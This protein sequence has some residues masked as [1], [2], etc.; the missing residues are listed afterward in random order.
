MRHWWN[1]LLS[2]EIST[3][4]NSSRSFLIE[5]SIQ[6]RLGILSSMGSLVIEGKE[7]SQYPPAQIF[8]LRD[9][10]SEEL[11]NWKKD[12]QPLTANDFF[13]L[14]THLLKRIHLIKPEIFIFEG[15]IQVKDTHYFGVNLIST[16]PVGALFFNIMF[17]PQESINLEDHYVI[18]HDPDLTLDL[19][20]VHL[21]STSLM[22]INLSTKEIL[23]IGHLSMGEIKE[24]I[25]S[26]MSIIL[27]QH[28]GLPMGARGIKDLEGSRCLV[29][30][31]DKS[32]DRKNLTND[33]LTFSGYDQFCLQDG[34]VQNLF[35]G[36]CLKES[37]LIEKSNE[38][39]LLK[40]HQFGN[41]FEGI[42]LDKITREPLLEAQPDKK[43]GHFIFSLP[44]FWHG[45]HHAFNPS[46]LFLFYEDFSGVFPLLG[47]L[48]KEE[49]LSYLL[50]ILHQTPHALSPLNIYE[51]L[52]SQFLDSHSL[53]VWRLN[54]G[55]EK[56]KDRS[57]IPSTLREVLKKK[58]KFHFYQHSIFP[59][60]VPTHM[61]HV[62]EKF[63]MPEKF[64]KKKHDYREV[65]LREKKQFAEKLQN[66]I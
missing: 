7:T 9:G 33:G 16:S 35:E 14:R 64:W 22:A 21:K 52:L 42:P 62:S 37:D 27:P 40:Y 51:H 3:H 54:I 41:M 36:A 56:I 38:E 66:V 1:S 65:A 43:E 5:K 44:D 15:K 57:L 49:A 46:F 23:M 53:Q 61:D 8:I 59:L 4:V 12:I 24:G 29:I 55:G 17:K 30:E 11:I 2:G 48:G 10:K 13:D 31:M 58:G 47:L 39:L 20:D 45:N 50:Y 26:L 60:L 19:F 28:G 63:L 32:Q 34:V 18:Y 25:L 6:K